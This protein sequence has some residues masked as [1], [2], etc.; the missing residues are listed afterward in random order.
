MKTFI[1]S[2]ALF[3][4]SAAMACPGGHLKTIKYNGKSAFVLNIVTG[5]IGLVSTNNDVAMTA[6]YVNDYQ[7]CGE[8]GAGN[9]VKCSK[10]F[11][12][13][14]IVT[15]NKDDVNLTTLTK[16]RDVKVQ[17]A[18]KDGLKIATINSFALARGGCGQ[19]IEAQ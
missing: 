6:L 3:A 15:I 9:K 8:V 7:M 19:E 2:L 16:L 10:V 14:N 1:L 13:F 12:S 5:K 11:P 17:L 4:T 18:G